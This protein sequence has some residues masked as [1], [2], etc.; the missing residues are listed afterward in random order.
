MLS[1]AL[2]IEAQPIQVIEGWVS[3]ITQNVLYID[4]GRYPLSRDVIV[5]LDSEE[6]RRITLRT[7]T[8]VGYID[9]ARLY[10]ENGDVI[11]IVILEVQ[12]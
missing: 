5:T 3:H 2:Y 4:G 8:K 10:I 9:K 12:Q 6:G 1:T 11:K 7:I